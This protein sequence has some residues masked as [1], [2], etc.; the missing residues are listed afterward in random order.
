MTTSDLDLDALRRA[1]DWG[2][3]FQRREPQLKLFPDVMPAEGTP[4]CSR[5]TS[6]PRWQR[7]VRVTAH[8]R[9]GLPGSLK[10]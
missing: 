4:A 10:N 3:A 8:S 7:R 5:R 1:L 2:H 6:T 9:T